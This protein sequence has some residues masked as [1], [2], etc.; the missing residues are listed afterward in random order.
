MPDADSRYPF[1]MNSIAFATRFGVSC[2]MCGWAGALA[3]SAWPNQQ[4]LALRILADALEQCL[5]GVLHPG[6][7]V[8]RVAPCHVWRQKFKGAESRHKCC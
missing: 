8:A 5:H 7:G 2:T 3:A 6:T 1:V 4:A